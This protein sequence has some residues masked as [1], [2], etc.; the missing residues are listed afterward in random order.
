MEKVH[1]HMTKTELIKLIAEKTDSTNTAAGKM[2]D[3]FIDIVSEVLS[4][5]DSVT[6]P[7]FGT[8]Y[9]GSRSERTGR[10]P[11]TGETITIKAAKVPRFRAGK[12]L[13]EDVNKK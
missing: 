5:D 4:K 12:Q 3:T 11:Q 1:N 9:V 10:N 7:G 13:K 2:F 8:F 6:I